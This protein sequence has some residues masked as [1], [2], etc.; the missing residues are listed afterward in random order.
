MF[1]QIFENKI[2][3]KLNNF[4]NSGKVA[5]EW[6]DKFRQSFDITEKIQQQFNNNDN[7]AAQLQTP[8]TPPSSSSS[9]V[10]NNNNINAGLANNSQQETEYYHNNSNINNN[11]NN[12]SNNL[13]NNSSAQKNRSNLPNGNHNGA[14]IN[15][16]ARSDASATKHL[17][18]E[19]S[20]ENSENLYAAS[21]SSSSGLTTNHHDT[22]DHNHQSN[23]YQQSNNSSPPASPSHHTPQA[24]SHNSLLLS[25][26][27][28]VK[29]SRAHHNQNHN[30]H[31]LDSEHS[32]MAKSEHHHLQQSKSV[33][34]DTGADDTPSYH[35]YEYYAKNGQST[36]TN[37]NNRT[38]VRQSTDLTSS[39]P[40]KPFQKINSETVEIPGLNVKVVRYRIENDLGKIEPHLY[41][42]YNSSGGDASTMASKGKLFFSLH[43]NEEIQSFSVTINK[44]EL[45]AGMNGGGGGG[46]Q[47]FNNSTSSSPN[48]TSSSLNTASSSVSAPNS[49]NLNKPDTYIKVQLLPDKKRKFQTRIQRKTWAP[50]FDETFYFPI[51]FEE[52]QNKTLY[53]SLLEFGRFSKHEL[54]GSVR[55]NDIHSIKDIT[56]TEVEFVR[57]LIPLADVSIHY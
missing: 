37:P 36:S 24:S 35:S 51:P 20:F 55:L 53:L 27:N 45:N 4:N 33:A 47:A 54:I 31:S 12:S 8:S 41:I 18:K 25:P 30:G 38:L 49:P 26:K 28:S 1:K 52:L 5:I 48:T 46:L 19:N 11:N 23:H 6:M 57:N 17:I 2:G 42:K 9:I 16:N 40:L 15:R 43:Y 56:T 3:E 22:Y 39:F 29:M 10:N 7:F 44:A 32:S 34:D 50:L 14:T 21:S 13:I